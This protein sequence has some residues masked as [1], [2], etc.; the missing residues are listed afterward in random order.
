MG[1]IRLSSFRPVRLVLGSAARH[2]IIGATSWLRILVAPIQA[3]W[4]QAF[5]MHSLFQDARDFLRK[6][7]V[8]RSRTTAQRL[9]QVVGDIC[10]DENAFAIS[11]LI[12]LSNL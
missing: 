10:A 8:L 4:W 3:A 2:G 5:P 12:R 1:R 9:L 6:R 7:P 11:H